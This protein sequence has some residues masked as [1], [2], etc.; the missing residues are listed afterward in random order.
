MLTLARLPLVYRV[1]ALELVLVLAILLRQLFAVL[2]ALERTG[3]RDHAS[4][5][6]GGSRFEPEACRLVLELEAAVRGPPKAVP[7]LELNPALKLEAAEWLEPVVASLL[8]VS[9]RSRG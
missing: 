3:L 1:N 6:C 4:R 2:A 5:G 8:L 9:S 7:E